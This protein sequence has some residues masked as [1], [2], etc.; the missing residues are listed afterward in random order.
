VAIRMVFVGRLC[1]DDQSAPND[2]GT[3]DIRERLDCVGDECV[4]M[5]EDARREFGSSL[6]RV[7]RHPRECGAQTS[8]EPAL[9]HTQR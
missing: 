2:D 9:R 3:E 4:G 1:S 8:I 7:D 6:N 5:T